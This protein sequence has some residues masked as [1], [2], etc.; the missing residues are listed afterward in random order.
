MVYTIKGLKYKD[1]EDE[2]G[3]FN[4]IQIM[5]NGSPIFSI[6]I[7]DGW[8]FLDKQIW[9]S[10]TSSLCYS[11]KISENTFVLF[12]VGPHEASQPTLLTI[13]AI[14]NDIAQLVHNHRYFVEKVEKIN[15]ITTMTLCENTVEWYNDNQPANEAIIR[16]MTIKNGNIYLK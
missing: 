2:L 3:D 10:V 16:T 11:E 14:Q 1:W 7:D 8:D 15:G 9:S 5:K 4:V 13:I 6:N 12:F